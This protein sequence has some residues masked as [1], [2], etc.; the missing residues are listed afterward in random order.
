MID[1]VLFDLDGTLFDRTTS[2]TQGLYR[3][4]ARFA[5]QLQKTPLDDFVARFTLLEERGYI[6][7]AT[8][9]A[10]LAA[11][12]GWSPAL[13]QTLCD[14]YA[15]RYHEDCIGF[16]GL[17]QMLADLRGL[18]LKLGIITNGWAEV[19]LR[20]IRALEME[21]YFD[22]ILVSETEG[23]R[24]P[25]AAIFERALNR[26]QT[27]ADRALF[28]GDHPLNDITGAQAVGMRA[29]WIRDDHWGECTHA[30]WRIDAL[31]ELLPI[32]LAE[33]NSI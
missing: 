22:T 17:H 30:D 9:Y 33:R 7:K 1:A 29:V 2:V 4:Y 31:G 3:Q 10:Q 24:K 20:V 25:D 15:E 28:V 13:A 14:D 21:A 12:F 16:P 23:V 27:S 11:E 19:Q 32:V 8:V 5:D 18:G 26:L 6:T